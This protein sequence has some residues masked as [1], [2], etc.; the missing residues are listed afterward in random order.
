[1]GSVSGVEDD[2]PSLADLGGV[3]PVDHLGGHEAERAVAMVGVV[4]GIER[5]A[6]GA[7]ILDGA[8]AVGEA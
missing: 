6:E 5:L 8:E 2:G 3:A 1:V 4:P 7:G